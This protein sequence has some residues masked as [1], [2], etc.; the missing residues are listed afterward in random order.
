[1]LK[2]FIEN[3]RGNQIGKE[4]IEQQKIDLINASDEKYQSDLQIMHGDDYP[5]SS[6]AFSGNFEIFRLEEIPSEI[7]DFADNSLALL[8][9]QAAENGKNYNSV[10]YTDYIRHNTDYYYL[11]RART[12]RGNPG[13]SSAIYKV[14]LLEDADEI[15][16]RLSTVNIQKQ[17][18][19]TFENKMRK[20]LQII[21]NKSQAIIDSSNLDYSL[22]PDNQ[23]NLNN[24][25]LS[26]PVNLDSLWDYNGKTKFFKIRLESKKT[27]KKIDLNVR[28]KFLKPT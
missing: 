4:E 25:R 20:Y 28:F 5:F 1:M 7:S 21:P 15:I 6:R 18:L 14:R 27:G 16:M 3:S 8:T 2:I 23:Q 24:L 22:D 9:A 13:I 26:N 11:I 10:S 19:F 17:E 12:H